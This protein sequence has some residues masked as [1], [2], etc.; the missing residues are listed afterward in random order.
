MKRRPW[1][2]RQRHDPRSTQSGYSN[3]ESEDGDNA[4]K[5]EDDFEYRE[6]EDYEIHLLDLLRRHGAKA[7]SEGPHSIR[8][9]LWK[10]IAHHTRTKTLSGRGGRWLK[11]GCWILR[12]VR[13]SG[14][15]V[16]GSHV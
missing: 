6:L 8:N 14:K 9:A 3:S 7:Y 2:E 1:E 5:L 16:M 11:L 15:G 13:L 10:T 4:D 12:S